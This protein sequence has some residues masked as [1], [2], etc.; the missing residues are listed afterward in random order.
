MAATKLTKTAMDRLRAPHPS[1]KQKL[2][3]DA[4]LKG[5]GLLLSGKTTARTYIVQRRLPDGRERRVTI[6]GVAEWEAAGKTVDDARAEAA[7]LLVDLRAGRDPK[8]ERRAGLTV[9]QVL[10]EYVATRT[11]LRQRSKDGMQKIA[12]RYLSD[13]LDRPL[14][15][16][17]G[18]MVDERHRTIQ[19]DVAAREK[20]RQREA[21]E[22]ARKRAK[23]KKPEGRARPPQDDEHAIRRTGHHSADGAMVVLRALWNFAAER[24]PNLHAL[25]NPVQRLRRAWFRSPQKDRR[26]RR[27]R[28]EQ[29]PAFH[30]AVRALE[31]TTARD[32]VLLLLYTGLRREEAASL[33]W[34]DLDFAERV[35]RIPSARTKAGR[36]LDLPMSD[37]VHELL[38]ARRA[39]G[40]EEYVFPADSERG[41]IAE[42]R[43]PLGEVAKATGIY[44]SAHDL[45][46][47]YIGIAEATDMSPYALK[48]LVNHSAGNDVTAGYLGMGTER[49]REP[50]QRVADRIRTLCEIQPPTGEKVKRLRR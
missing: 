14:R 8:V 29:L 50:A 37:L 3:W 5:F 15:Q 47:T 45:R 40:K 2:V 20:E 43:Y 17:T 38:V 22:R 21:T 48:A 10:D 26:E 35:I 33:K 25:P 49:L 27:V 9:Q 6:A 23:E 34:T 13:W 12:D 46:R 1:G 11:S 19:R 36:R 39:K 4:E 41:Y 44:V 32:Y 16:I 7:K 42:P 28:S 18:D 31:S 30:G 24:D